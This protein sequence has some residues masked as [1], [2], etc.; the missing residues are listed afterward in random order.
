MLGR[1]KLIGPWAGLPV[2][3]RHDWVFDEGAYRANVVR[4]CRAG[5][6]G[7]YTCGTSGEFYAM[8]MDEFK[9]VSRATIEEC[10]N[11]DTPVLIGVTSTYTLGAQRR[12]A[13]AA[14]L[15]ADGVQVAL[16]FWM[17]LD[18]RDV[19]PFFVDVMSACPGLALTIYETTR[20]K[21]SLTLDQHRAIFEAIPAYRAVKA[22]GGTFG[23]TVEGCSALSEFVNVWVSEHRW[24][25]L[26][27]HGAIGCAS[28]MV[29]LN[30]RVILNMFDLLK[31]QK[32]EELQPWTDR[33]R[34]FTLEGLAPL[35]AKGF[36]DSAYD[37]VL[38]LVAG[39][40][41]MHPRSRGPYLSAIDEDVVQLREWLRANLPEFLEL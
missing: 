37:H 15:G 28:A 4:T 32:W 25:E 26:G 20:C 38:G 24:S 33:V 5:V 21:K 8:E 6:P 18:D 1:D 27:P 40:L 10:K 13:Y 14:E 2:A 12:A 34:R 36:Q 9:G 17:E 3:W 22:N 30:P 23:C 35:T 29:Y 16:P 41:K 31:Q 7:V 39:F 11:H 19:I